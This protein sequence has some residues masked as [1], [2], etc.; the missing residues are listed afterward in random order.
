M[1][2]QSSAEDALKDIRT[3]YESRRHTVPD[4]EASRTLHVAWN[5][6]ERLELKRG[7][8]GAE[9][10]VWGLMMG[11]LGIGMTSLVCSRAK[12]GNDSDCGWTTFGLLIFG[13]PVAIATGAVIGAHR[14]QWVPIH[15]SPETP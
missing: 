6:I 3:G 7:T 15:C 5:D 8:L 13:L 10:A 1:H 12:K 2:A 4:G 9:G 14:A 11:A